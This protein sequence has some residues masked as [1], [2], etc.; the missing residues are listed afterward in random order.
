MGESNLNQLRGKTKAQTFEA[1]PEVGRIKTRH[2][3]QA[4]DQNRRF[5][6]Q[7]I[8][9]WVAVLWEVIMFVGG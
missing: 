7:V 6:E 9:V 8:E 5:I 4:R 1:A 2:S 3:F